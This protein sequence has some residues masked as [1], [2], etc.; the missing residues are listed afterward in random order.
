MDFYHS[1]VAVWVNSAPQ[2]KRWGPRAHR[3]IT[4]AEWRIYVSVIEPL[5][6][7]IMA[8]HLVGTKP[9][10]W[11]NDGIL[12]IGL[13]GTNF[14]EIFIEIHAFSFK[15]MHLKRSSA[16]WQP[17]CLSLNVLTFSYYQEW[18]SQNRPKAQKHEI[19]IFPDQHLMYHISSMIFINQLIVAW[20]HH[21]ATRNWVNIG[22]GN[23]LLPDGTK[24]LPEP[25]LTYH[26]YGPV[27]FIGWHYHE[28]IWYQSVK[29][30]W[31]L[32]F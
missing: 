26:Q 7:Q 12:L 19:K 4:E 8:C 28:K 1:P 14:S 3:G 24:P 25:M 17:C 15:K 9:I 16:K 13:Q 31:K 30:D 11:P 21:K 22:S 27:A 29:Q 6:V 23:G 18:S 32:H 5:L 20:R 2:P 10:I